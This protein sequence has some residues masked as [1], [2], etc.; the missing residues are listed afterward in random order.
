MCGGVSELE[1]DGD[2]MLQQWGTDCFLVVSSQ[3]E[4]AR[5]TGS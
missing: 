1:W 2:T 4:T 3:T 5:N